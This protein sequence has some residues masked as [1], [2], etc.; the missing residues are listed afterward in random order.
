MRYLEQIEQNDL[1]EFE[2]MTVVN[3]Y[4]DELDSEEGF[5]DL[6]EEEFGLDE[7]FEADED[8]FGLG[9]DDMDDDF[10]LEEEGEEDDYDFEEE[11]A[12]D[13]L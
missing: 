3:E 1:H 9:E 7:D 10:D 12:E 2:L 6:E 11:E 4:D 8:G 13:E 5:D